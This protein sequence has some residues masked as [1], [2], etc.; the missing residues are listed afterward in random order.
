VQDLGPGKEQPVFFTAELSTPALPSILFFLSSR[1]KDRLLRKRKTHHRM[2]ATSELR[3]RHV[4]KSHK[5]Y[6]KF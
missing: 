1:T 2:G 3:K 5:V 4:L 6:F